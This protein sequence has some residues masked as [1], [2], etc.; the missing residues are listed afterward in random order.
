[1]QLRRTNLDTGQVT[2]ILVPCGATLE[3]VCPACAKRAQSLRAEQCR[4]GWHLEEEPP[5]NR[6]ATDNDQE[7]WLGLRARAQV[8]RDQ[9]ATSGEDT[10][11]LDEAVTVHREI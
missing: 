11:E 7:F 5:D 8:L 9:V 4:D 2:Q 6:P 1:M 3:S 10:S